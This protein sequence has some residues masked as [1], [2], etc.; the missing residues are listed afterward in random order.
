MSDVLR[1]VIAR[2]STVDRHVSRLSRIEVTGGDISARDNASLSVAA[3]N[4]ASV[5]I[6]LHDRS[7]IDD[8]ELLR[9]VYRFAGET[10]DEEALNR[11]E[12]TVSSQPGNTLRRPVGKDD[13]DL[14]TGEEKQPD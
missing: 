6:Q 7:L 11:P 1:V 9:L 10:L 14:E 8:S 2:R 5:F 12:A 4:I 13:L 3:N